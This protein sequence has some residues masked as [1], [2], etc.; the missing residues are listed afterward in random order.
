MFDRIEAGTFVIAGA[1]ASQKLKIVG[2]EPKILKK[3][4]RSF[5][6]NGS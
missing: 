3:E 4:L 5:K 6:K 1:L 2:V